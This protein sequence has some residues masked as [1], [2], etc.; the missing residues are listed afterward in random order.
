MGAHFSGVRHGDESKRHVVRDVR[1]AFQRF[2]QDDASTQVGSFGLG[3]VLIGV[4]F[5]FPATAHISPFLALFYYY[6]TSFENPKLKLPIFMPISAKVTD[7]NNYI[8]GVDTDGKMADGNV[9]LGNDRERDGAEVWVNSDVALRHAIGYGTTGSGKSEYLYA[10][11]LSILC[12][13]AS[14]IFFDGKAGAEAGRKF[15]NLIR[16][17]GREDCLNYANYMTAGNDGNKYYRTSNCTNPL[18]TANGDEANQFITNFI[19]KSDGNNKIFAERAATVCSLTTDILFDRRENEIGYTVSFSDYESGMQMGALLSCLR[20]PWLSEKSRRAVVAYLQG[21]NIDSPEEVKI[22]EIKQ[23]PLD[24][25]LYATMHFTRA[26]Y[27]I[28]ETYGYIFNTRYGDYNW[29]D[30]INRKRIIMIMLP[31]MEKA[32]QER[33]YLVNLNVAL[34]KTTASKFLDYKLTGAKE[35]TQHLPHDKSLSLIVFDEANYLLTEGIG[36][37]AGQLRSMKFSLQLWGQSRGAM[38]ERN[39]KEMME[40]EGNTGLKWYGALEDMPAIKDAIERADSI[41]V[42]VVDSLEGDSTTGYWKGKGGQQQKRE[43]L[44]V[45]DIKG[46]RLSEWTLLYKDEVIR[47]NSMYIAEL[48]NLPPFTRVNELCHPCDKELPSWLSKKMALSEKNGGVEHVELPDDLED[49]LAVEQTLKFNDL[50]KS[51][52][53]KMAG[54]SDLD[55][56]MRGHLEVELQKQRIKA[57]DIRRSDHDFFK[58]YDDEYKEYNK[59]ID[60]TMDLGGEGAFDAAFD[61]DE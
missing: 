48:D 17:F 52:D 37:M 29:P 41:Y 34:L 16:R 20:K 61:D 26:L 6:L 2:R 59:I 38:I 43:R 54:Y 28:T 53:K 12:Q 31:S 5:F 35:D 50:F 46:Q 56:I 11:Y 42:D 23:T 40:I 14:L 32:D 58:N 24:Q 33:D 51:N 57:M 13:S 60:S 18:S 10:I 49:D 45:K 30:I 9:F 19:P 25:H 21:L 36:I 7:P 44:T 4:V 8:A 3:I 27:S 55:E 39:K 22:K 47:L 15:Q 1:S